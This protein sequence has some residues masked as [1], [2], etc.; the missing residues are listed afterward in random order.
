MHVSATTATVTAVNA[1]RAAGVPQGSA[2]LQADL[3]VDA[4]L[5]GLASHGMLRLPRILERID[6]GVANPATTGRQ[7]WVADAL[8]DV[9]GENGLGPVV[10][11]A[12]LD[13]IS[14][15]AKTTG[16]ACTTIRANNHL[17][18]L[19]WYVRRIATGGQICLAMTTS[20]AITHPYGGRTALIGSNPIA[21]GVPAQPSP[22]VFDMA[23]SLVSMGKI[24]DH[25]NRGRELEPGWALDRAGEPTTDPVAA[26]DGAIAP[27]GGA[28][29][30]G[31]GIAIEVLVASLTNTALGT[32]VKGTLD[33]VHAPTK[34]D[35]FIVIQ[36]NSSDP[37][38]AVSAYLDE[39]RTSPATSADTPVTV[40]GDRSE[41]RRRLTESDG[42]D[43]P[44]AIW[45]HLVARAQAVTGTHTQERLHQQ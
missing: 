4:E 38:T 36:P 1:L 23:T 9:D 31:L 45:Q 15:R 43:V 10:A 3:L 35:I 20:E 40:P 13:A 33:S 28:K 22:L 42:F 29:G 32:Q 37:I 34:G 27:F 16:I 41:T 44:D 6:N 2:E 21:F 7:Q 30:Y 17:G 24:H 14:E 26:K 25:A 5:R 18:A 19:A 8:L 12:A 11:T 39:V